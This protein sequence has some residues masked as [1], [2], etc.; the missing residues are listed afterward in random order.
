MRDKNYSLRVAYLV[1]H[2]NGYKL[3]EEGKRDERGTNS[4]QRVTHSDILQ[5]LDKK[6]VSDK[7]R[8]EIFKGAFH[9]ICT[10]RAL[11]FFGIVF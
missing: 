2:N 4:Y 11:I 5:Y 7:Q 8:Y 1:C 6:G 10:P 3:E 9:R